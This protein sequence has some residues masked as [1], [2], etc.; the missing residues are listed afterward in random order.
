MKINILFKIN[1]E[2]EWL[3]VYAIFKQP[4]KKKSDN[5]KI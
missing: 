4:Q 3:L 1:R 2:K 5:T